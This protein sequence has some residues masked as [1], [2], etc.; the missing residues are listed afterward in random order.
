MVD[1]IV[2]KEEAISYFIEQGYSKIDAEKLA[3]VAI[4]V[5]GETD[6]CKTVE[7]IKMLLLKG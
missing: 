4:E 7:K 1:I 2:T 6:F 3:D 5:K